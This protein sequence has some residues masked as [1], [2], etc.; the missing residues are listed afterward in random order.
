MD[1]EDNS[2]L[3]RWQR[4]GKTATSLGGFA[5]RYF[6]SSDK[7]A[8]ADPLT[9]ILGNLK[10]PVMKVAQ[11]LSTVPDILPPE[12]VA[13]LSELQSEAP[14][15]GWLFV[16]RR[17]RGELGADWEE[18]F[19]SFEKQATAAASL[20]QVHKATY[21]DSTPLACKLQYPDMTSTVE[22]DLQQVKMFFKLYEQSQGSLQVTHVFEE[23][24]ARLREELDYR[25]EAKNLQTFREIFQGDDPIHI[26]EVYEGLS[27][28]RLLTMEWLEGEK[29]TT[30]ENAP[31]D[32]RNT[33]AENLFRAWY[34]PLYQHGILHSDPH[35]GNY[36]VTP[37]GDI[38]LFDFGC[39]RRFEPH[40]IE[41]ILMLYKALQEEN[42]KLA[43]EAYT[44]WGFKNL[45]DELIETLNLWAHYLYDPILDNRVRHIDP[46]LNS[47]R[48]QALAGKIHQQLKEIGGIAPPREFVFMDRVAVGLGSA[49]IRLK[50]NL[51]WHDL[52]HGML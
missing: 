22:A 32:L 30:F 17:M 44:L 5:A 29:I 41:G 19:Q 48:G 45:S 24:A 28:E 18:K 36:T 43:A 34:K 2:F 21:L 39:V 50:A 27:T 25:Q 11:I 8:L 47:K 6:L 49:F 31:Q 37:T 16:K 26:P 14:P 51:N 15:M 52:F 12:Y 42:K 33:I 10:G 20:G 13:K 46:D 9:A 23:I 1:R 3:K 40:F 38:N 7:E 4:H 35:L